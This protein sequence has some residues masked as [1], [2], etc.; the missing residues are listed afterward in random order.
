MFLSQMFPVFSSCLPHVDSHM[1]RKS[2]LQHRINVISQSCMKGWNLNDV[3]L[4]S[5]CFISLN[6]QCVLFT[7]K[8]LIV[9]LDVNN[10]TSCCNYN[11]LVYWC[12][13]WCN[14]SLPQYFWIYWTNNKKNAFNVF[15]LWFD[16]SYVF[17]NISSTIVI[18]YY[19]I[20][21]CSRNITLSYV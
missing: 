15:L 1:K 8:V 6:L 19:V 7:F 12:C 10:I 13:F 5:V 17:Y 20:K 3:N 11:K 21:R 16:L 18:N 9:H 4:A 14:L 2:N